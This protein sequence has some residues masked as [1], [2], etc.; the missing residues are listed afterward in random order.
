M[1]PAV[2]RFFEQISDA[3]RASPFEVVLSLVLI[4]GLVAG[5]VAYAI[6]W[7]RRERRQ[8]VTLA[9]KLFAEKASELQLSPSQMALL[10]R[11]AHHLRDPSQLHHL[12]TDEV[13]F[14]AAAAKLR[15]TG[16]A[17]AQTIASL[18]VTLGLH[19]GPSDRAPRSSAAIPEGSVVLVARNRYRRPSKAKVLAPQPGAFRVRLIE[20]ETRLPPG[21]GV[22]VFFQSSAGVFTFHTTVLAESPTEARLSHSEDLK[23]YQKRRYYRRRVE[24]PVHLYPFDAEKP[25]LSKSRDIG[26]GGASLLNPD[27]HFKVGDELEMRF[28]PDDAEIRITGTVVRVSDSG[29]TIHV[30]YE[31]IRDALRDRIYN[32]IFKPPKDELDEME[33][34]A[35]KAARSQGSKRTE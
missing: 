3:Y 11:M 27:G 30:N 8:Q 13:A 12:V 32:A 28:Q 20:K 34:A 17:N 14:N 5:L 31:H 22:D 35:G 29:R 6:Y 10:E 16:E 1:T 21:A 15:E 23:R 4:L 2:Q 26:G 7:S 18:R 9:R 19:Q 24:L 33:R 25:L